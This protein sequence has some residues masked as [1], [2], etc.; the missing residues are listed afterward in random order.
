MKFDEDIAT[1]LE[2]TGRISLILGKVFVGRQDNHLAW[3]L[4]KGPGGPVVELDTGDKM[5]W[6]RFTGDEDEFFVLS[7]IQRLALT[8]AA[9]LAGYGC[10]PVVEEDE[11]AIPPDEAPPETP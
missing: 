1:I 5:V 4:T 8:G 3:Y 11:S 9:A 6:I 2:L 7:D 10:E